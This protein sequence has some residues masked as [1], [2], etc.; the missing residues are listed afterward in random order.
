M[1]RTFII[2][3]LLLFVGVVKSAFYDFRKVTFAGIHLNN[4]ETL[5]EKINKLKSNGIRDLFT[6]RI[7]N[8]GASHVIILG[9]C[10]SNI[11][12]FLVWFT[13][14]KTYVQAFDECYTY[15]PKEI[16]ATELF[17]LYTKNSALIIKENVLPALAKGS[18]MDIFTFEILDRDT[19]V[20]KQFDYEYDL[21]S[22]KFFPD[23]YSTPEYKKAL[24]IYKANI[25]TNLSK[26]LP[27]MI[28][29]R[30]QYYKNLESDKIQKVS[31]G[32]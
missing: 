20:K 18:H 16:D 5:S 11:T 19:L 7:H 9:G 4:A 1:K 14:R 25:Q 30:I 29:A 23:A 6:F 27:L 21:D 8:D 12:K 10:S 32:L 17:N 22:P 2:V 13:D 28:K 26:L 31:G 24:G 3:T 15:N